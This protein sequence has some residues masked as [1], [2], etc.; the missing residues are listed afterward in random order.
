MNSFFERYKTAILFLILVVLLGAGY[1]YQQ[2]QVSLFPEITFPKLKVIAD[3]GEQPVDMM[4]ITVTKPLEEAIRQVPGSRIIRSVT[5]RGSTEINVFLDWKAD[6]YRT[7]QLMESKISEIG[8]ILPPNVQITVARMNP[9]ILPVFGYSLEGKGRSLIELKKLAEL[10]AKPFF[11][12]IENVGGV[13]VQGG[14][15]KEYQIELQPDKMAELGITPQDVANAV[16]QTGFIA[17]NGYLNDYRRLYLTLT[18]AGLDD[19][20]DLRHLVL[21][22]DGIRAVTVEDIATLHVGEKLEY[23]KINANGHEGV[24]VNILKQPNG[25][26]MKLAAAIDAR[27]PELKQLLPEGVEL[28]PIYRQS[29]FVDGSIKSVQDALLLGLGLAILITILFL[30][31]LRASLAVLLVIPLT[32]GLT[33]IALYAVGYTLNIMTLGA[34]AAAIGL[35]IDDAIVVVE[36]IHRIREER[37]GI[38]V[39]EAIQHSLKLLLP[40]LV[41]SSLSTLVI[42]IP[43]S[44]M[45]GVA[46]A[47]FKVLAYT[48]IIALGCSFLAAAVGLPVI[49]RVVSFGK[50]RKHREAHHIHERRWVV[51]FIKNPWLSM[52]FAAILVATIIL[53]FPKLQTGFLPEMDEGT[54]VLDY[55]SPPGTSI[56][57]TNRMLEQVDAIITAN[58]EVASYNRRTGAQMGFF[59]TEPNRGDYLISL[60]KKRRHSTEEVIAD[61]RKHIE[62]ALPVLTVDFGQVIGDMLGDLMSSVQPIEVKIFGNG[63]EKVRS[64][65]KSAA[66]IVEETP[67][68][69]DVFDG[70]VIAGPNISYLP[71][72]KNLYRFGLTPADLKFQLEARTQGVVVGKLKE[73]EQ[74]I[75]VRMLYP[76]AIHNSLDNMKNTPL[77]LPDGSQMPLHL[78]TDV[79]VEKGVPEI[80]RENLQLLTAVTARLDNRDLGSVMKDIQK[81]VKAEIPLPKGYRIEYGGSFAEQQQSFRELLAILVLAGL[82]VFTVLLVLFR[83]LRVALAILFVSALGLAGCYLALYLTGTPLNVGSYTGIIMIVG[84][85]AEN[86]IFTFQQ[87]Q[88]AR[89]NHTVEEALSYAIAARLRPKL[90]TA[91]GAIMALM[92]L[93][94][95]IGTGAQMHQPLAIAVIG[96]LVLALPLLLIVLP[97]LLRVV[98]RKN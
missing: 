51:F 30:R 73:Q 44:L 64:I 59:I 88:M 9:A 48:M 56:E 13:Q 91:S 63:P 37:P 71:N 17:S 34:I 69:A 36:Q 84:I 11:S 82:L 62:A 52:L 15:E 45:S 65:A 93:A 2:L 60:K 27:L 4:M 57:E 61:L 25:D 81:R 39:P 75:N 97:S 28:K 86:S 19:L 14:K 49:Y 35:M 66:R 98:F 79:Q 1:S 3:N 31:S 41:G 18:D 90:M 77:F 22:N 74:L 95:G 85:I 96:G 92:P 29:E 53:V 24:L 50:D 80:E 26:L 72:E 16:G 6:I 23:I 54:I 43:F 12:Q 68:T 7:Q 67:G 87:F 5:S 8:N 47:Y 20:D 70:I 78:L 10:T 55:N 46:G 40:V 76:D 89:T 83:D 38:G 32:L 42:F 33:L 21:R 94:L 58:P